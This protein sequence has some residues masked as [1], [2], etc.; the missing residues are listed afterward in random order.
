MPKRKR[1]IRV[2]RDNEKKN[3]Y[4]GLSLAKSYYF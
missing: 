2:D 3:K 4:M 1:A